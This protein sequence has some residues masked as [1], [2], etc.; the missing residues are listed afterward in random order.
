MLRAVSLFTNCGA[1]DSGFAAAGFE[2]KV[3]AEL[4]EARLSVAALNHPA[5]IPVPGDL[6]RTLPD[7]VRAYRQAARGA[8]PALLAA[9]PPCQGLSSARGERGKE[10][11]ADAGSLDDRNLLVSVIADAARE[12]KPRLVVVEN[13]PAFMRRLVRHPHTN[14]AISAARYL[15]D[16]LHDYE[17]FP[18]LADLADFGVPQRRKRCFL[19]FI[20]RDEP[21]LGLL[22]THGRV[23]YP[24]PSHAE[25]QVTVRD[26]L[27]DLHLPRLDSKTERAAR[28]DVPMHFVHVLPQS[29]YRMVATIPADS[30][31]GAWANNQCL[32]CSKLA[33]DANAASCG[34]C[35]AALPRPIVVDSNGSLRLVAG[36]RRSSYTRMSPDEPASTITTASGRIGSDRTLHPSEHRVLSPLECLHLQTFSSEF[37]WGEALSSCGV[38]EVRAMI[39]EAVPPLFTHKH[40]QVLTSW[41]RGAPADSM[42]RDD[43]RFVRAE[44]ALPLVPTYKHSDGKDHGP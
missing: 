28:S 35:G 12:L 9:C 29:L 3:I 7:V 32:E 10:D 23:P 26:A 18:L 41:L 19:T 36:F 37:Q 21:A 5:A 4:R 34:L 25:R 11:D 33:T 27:A 2:F 43:P 8:R 24:I 20:R 30:G 44:K 1:G 38:T 15:I 40:G 16:T 31:L 39:G 13:V 14:E 6:R 17:V 42:T 22:R